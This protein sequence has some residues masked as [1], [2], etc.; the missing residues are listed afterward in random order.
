MYCKLSD[1][2]NLANGYKGINS[3]K[4]YC[5][6][7]NKRR[8]SYFCTVLIVAKCIV[9]IFEISIK[10]CSIK[11]LIVAKCIVNLPNNLKRLIKSSY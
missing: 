6:Y 1:I 3:S 10:I 11:V 2:V 5:K 9:N 4:V 7:R 8:Y